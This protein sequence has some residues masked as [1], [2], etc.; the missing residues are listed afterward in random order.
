MPDWLKRRLGLPP[1]ERLIGE[2]AAAMRAA[3]MGSRTVP[4]MEQ[5][6][7]GLADG[8]DASAA[9]AALS[10]WLAGRS[11]H[12]MM[13]GWARGLYTPSQAVARAV[14]HGIRMPGLRDQLRCVRARGSARPGGSVRWSIEPVISET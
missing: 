8:A 14:E 2:A 11:P 13:A 9:F 4:T 1:D 12:Q 6:R 10:C 3:S 5:V 7:R